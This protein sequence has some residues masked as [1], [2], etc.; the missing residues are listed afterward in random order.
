[1][2]ALTSQQWVIAFQWNY[3]GNLI[4]KKISKQEATRD[5]LNGAVIRIGREKPSCNLYLEDISVSGQHA[6][7]YFDEQQQKFF[8]KSLSPKNTTKVDGQDLVYGEE[9]PLKNG[10]NIVLG[11]LNIEVTNIQVYELEATNYSGFVNP[12]PNSNPVNSVSPSSNSNPVNSNI[13]SIP[14]NLNPNSNPVNLNVNL[15]NTDPEPDSNKS[16]RWWQEPTIQVAII[17]AVV[18]IVTAAVTWYNNNQTQQT[19]I[20]KSQLATNSA[21]KL[22]Y[23]ERLES[24]KKEV[25]KLLEKD[26]KTGNLIYSR[27][28][29][30]SDCNKFITFAVSYIA[31]NDVEETKGWFNLTN[32]RPIVPSFYTKKTFIRLHAYIEDSRYTNLYNA[33][34]QSYTEPWKQED[35]DK[36]LDGSS[37]LNKEKTNYRN[38]Q[39]KGNDGLVER[40]IIYP[41]DF[42]Y[43][44]N[45]LFFDRDKKDIIDKVKFYT[46]NFMYAPSGTQYTKAK[47]S[48]EGENLTLKIEE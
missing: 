9:L 35:I 43:I 33:L 12:K 26:E 5:N 6:E 2:N 48:C 17:S 3:N 16:K 47:F 10:S 27:L 40:K 15:R 22:K 23:I 32:E 34:K 18:G 38:K 37:E 21:E 41:S 24:H 36:Y 42:D 28:Q 4:N 11:Q 45:P 1:M 19:E 7:I 20:L 25:I 13:S 29:L 8:I 31:P 14:V 44:E 30:T 39:W 46:L